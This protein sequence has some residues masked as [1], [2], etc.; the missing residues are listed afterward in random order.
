M[1]IDPKITASGLYKG[2]KEKPDVARMIDDAYKEAERSK[3]TRL[4]KNTRN[5]NMFLGIQDWSDKP[6]GMSRETLPKVGM[7]CEQLAAF[8]SRGL[9]QGGPD[10]YELVVPARNSL[11]TGIELK[12]ILDYFLESIPNGNSSPKSISEIITDG[13]KIASLESLAIF[14]IHGQFI[15]SI[16]VSDAGIEKKPV[17]KLR[18][19]NIPFE[20]YYPDPTGRNLYEIHEYEMDLWE[21]QDRAAEGLYIKSVVNQ[22]T[23]SQT[24]EDND[25]K[26]DYEKMGQD[27]DGGSCH[28]KKIVIREF[29]GTLLN[30]D[31]SVY[32]RN[33]HAVLA[34]SRFVIREP[35][36]NPFYHNSSPFVCAPL[37]TIPFSVMHKALFDEGSDINVAMNEL[38][39]LMLDGAIGSVWG[40]SQLK[41]EYLLDP[42]SVESLGQGDVLQVSSTMPPGEK[43]LEKINESQIP[44]DAFAMFEALN[45]EFMASA[46]STE[47]KMGQMPGRKVLATEIVELNQSQNLVLD[48]LIGQIE[49]RLLVPLLSKCLSVVLQ[50]LP[51]TGVSTLEN[52]LNSDALMAVGDILSMDGGKGEL[53]Y[54]TVITRTGV[55]VRGLTQMMNRVRDFQ[56]VMALSQAIMT[57]PM[58]QMAFFQKYSP[59]SLLGYILKSLEIDPS[60]IER[61]GSEFDRYR[62]IQEELLMMQQMQSGSMGSASGE[63]SETGESGETNNPNISG[64]NSPEIASVNQQINPMTGFAPNE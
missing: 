39:S 23:E 63:P 55:K 37:I 1:K 19:D 30:Q 32:M 52:L 45:R 7:A 8:I 5:M 44:Q 64:M 51:H 47:L 24:I 13:I 62:T 34:N 49:R 15:P 33:C 2:T 40:I 22:L 56:K 60:D 17:W 18:V 46:L 16:E 26:R 12:S 48:A 3:E 59:T 27:D 61:T 38:F 53:L 6:S 54:A 10:W 57:N 42:S 20:S 50:H 25:K 35:E 58:L 43:V 21:V 28:R 41:R 31:G 14:K 36:E 9:V 11:L 29:W 4:C